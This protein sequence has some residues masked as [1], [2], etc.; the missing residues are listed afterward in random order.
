MINQ[1]QNR[2]RLGQK[3][4][5]LLRPRLAS[6]QARPASTG[7][8]G[9]EASKRQK[10]ANCLK[11][12][13]VIF[14][15]F[16]NF[17]N[18]IPSTYAISPSPIPSV[19]TKPIVTPKVSIVP[20]LTISP[21]LSATPSAPEEEKVQEIRQAIKDKVEQIKDKIEKKAYVG[22]I[23]EITDS[24]IVLN[25][26]RGKQRIRIT[27]DTKIVESKKEIK[28]KELAVDDKIISMGTI[29]DNDILQASRIVVV[30]KSTI[31]TIKKLSFFGKI[32]TIDTKI[33]LI[34]ISAMKNKDSTLDIKA[35]KISKIYLPDQ[36]TEIKIKDLKE[37][38]KIVVIY[39]Q[40]GADKTPVAKTIYLLP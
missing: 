26:F 36:K 18:P 34:D 23:T 30:P 12:F 32:T 16:I 8:G 6:T 28:P 17:I 15:I 29:S 40:T 11:V 33:S 7:Q 9:S 24:V 25:N 19:T 2:V 31:Q 5:G 21:S 4:K 10:L 35:D 20:T 13:I 38:Q 37:D 39:P 14:I 3:S 22:N 27:D 1:S